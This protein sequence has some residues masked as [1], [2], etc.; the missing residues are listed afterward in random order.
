MIF[1]TNSRT[2]ASV[3]ADTEKETAGASRHSAT[4]S[5]IL[6]PDAASR[7]EFAW[8]AVRRDGRGLCRSLPRGL[9]APGRPTE[10]EWRPP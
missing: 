1:L 2:V 8:S 10:S 3:K 4:C 9:D 6:F 5:Q 7:P